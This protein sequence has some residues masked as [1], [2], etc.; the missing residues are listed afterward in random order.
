MKKVSACE[1]PYI[2]TFGILIIV[3]QFIVCTKIK[4]KATV[5]I[6]VNRPLL[7]ALAF[8]VHFFWKILIVTVCIL[9]QAPVIYV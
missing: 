6:N 1:T 4:S 2:E 7:I 5:R 8:L 9:P 3:T